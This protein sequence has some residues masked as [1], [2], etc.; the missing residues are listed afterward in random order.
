MVGGLHKAGVK[1]GCYKVRTLMRKLGLKP[2]YPKRFKVTTDSHHNEAIP[3][4]SLDRNFDVVAPNKV[5]TTDITYVWTL[6]GWLYVAIVLDLFSRQIVG[7]PM[8]DPMR[9]SLCTTAL[10]MAFWRRK[11]EPGLPHHPDRGSQ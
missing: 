4:N 3:P 1:A 2:R 11:P 5:W 9:T 10:Q 7:W 8:A 6:E